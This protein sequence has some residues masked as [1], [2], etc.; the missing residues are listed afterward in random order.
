VDLKRFG[1]AWKVS[2]RNQHLSFISLLIFLLKIMASRDNDKQSIPELIYDVGSNVTY[3]KGRFF[4][5]V[6][7]S[8]PVSSRLLGTDFISTET[9][10][11]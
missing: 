10:V 8:L 2:T 6:S 1:L 5:K 7:V 3:R 4:G 11:V 9:S